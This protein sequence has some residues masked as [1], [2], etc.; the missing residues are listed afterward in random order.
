MAVHYVLGSRVGDPAIR[1]DQ[2]EAVIYKIGQDGSK[3]LAAVEYVVIADD[4]ANAGHDAAP[5]L[6][7]RTFTL[8]ASPNRYGLPAFF[9]LHAWI[10]DTNQA[11]ITMALWFDS[12]AHGKYAEPGAIVGQQATVSYAKAGGGRLSARWMPT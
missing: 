3:H 9:E 12:T 4:W 7:G 5:A 6:F 8:V 2:P 10:W 1:A 11:G